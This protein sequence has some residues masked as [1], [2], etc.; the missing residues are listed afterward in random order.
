MQTVNK[1]HETT[2]TK[3]K[4]FLILLLL[5]PILGLAYSGWHLWILLPL[6][7]LWKAAIIAMGTLCFLTLLLDFSGS[8][9]R[10]P[11]SLARILYRI[12]TSSVIVLLYV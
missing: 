2:K 10:M 3:R 7:S 5:L 8:L 6:P 9:E 11:L 4:M 1:K 12:G